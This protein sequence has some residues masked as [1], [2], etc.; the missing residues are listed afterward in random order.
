MEENVSLEIWI[1]ATLFGGVGATIVNI[2][3]HLIQ[4]KLRKINII[5]SFKREL[6]FNINHV[7]NTILKL[8]ELKEEYIQFDRR[9]K[10]YHFF[11][12]THSAVIFRTMINHGILYELLNDDQILKFDNFVFGYSEGAQ[13]ILNETID[14]IK[15]VHCTK[16]EAA[17]KVDFSLRQ[18]KSL[19]NDLEL[20]YQNI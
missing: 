14:E 13:Q 17:N 1:I 20:I 8:R 2:L 3:F 10:F 6:R 19:I 5:K 9:D 12:F 16:D 7:N 18:Y 15:S 11:K 4:G